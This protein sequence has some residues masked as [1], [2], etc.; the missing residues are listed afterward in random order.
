MKDLKGKNLTV[1]SYDVLV[2]QQDVKDG[3]N[4]K[5]SLE[6]EEALVFT[7]IKK[8]KIRELTEHFIKGFVEAILVLVT[9]GISGLVLDDRVQKAL[10]EH[11]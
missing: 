3:I 4:Q 1:F 11:Y 10:E 8:S 2:I 5:K 7:T 9:G 6:T